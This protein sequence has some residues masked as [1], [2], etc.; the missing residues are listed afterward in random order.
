MLGQTEFTTYRVSISTHVL[1][2]NNQL[3]LAGSSQAGNDLWRRA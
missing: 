1:D 3:E 2:R